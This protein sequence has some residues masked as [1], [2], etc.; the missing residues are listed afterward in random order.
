MVYVV[1][2]LCALIFF[3][4]Q[5]Y[6]Y[7]K[8]AEK[9][10]QIEIEKSWGNVPDR[11]YS[12]E[13]LENISRYYDLKKESKFQIDDITWND[14]DLDRIFALMNHSYSSVGDEFLYAWLRT[15]VKEIKELERRDQLISFFEEHSETAKK[16]SFL[17]S[18]LGRTKKGSVYENLKNLDSVGKRSNFIHYIHL[19]LFIVSLLSFFINSALGIGLLVLTTAYNVI[20]YYR[21]KAEVDTYFIC[22]RYILALVETSKQILKIEGEEL[23]EYQDELQQ[24]IKTLKKL[25]SGR[26]LVG[27][28][29]SSGDLSE[30]ILDYV[31]MLTHIDL[32][33]IN[34][35]LT[36]AIER[37]QDV[38]RIYACLGRIEACISVASFR[39]MLPYYAKFNYQSGE[40]ILAKKIYHPL[41]QN[42][43]AN[44][45]DEEQVVLLTG[46]NASGKSTFL[47]TIAI[48]AI[49]AQTIF[50]A[51]AK[52]FQSDFYQ[53]YSSMALHDNLANNE[54]YYIV[55]IKSLKRIL[56]AAKQKTKI[57]CFVDE[58][59]RGT[60]TVERIAASSRILKDM[61]DKNIKVFAATH[62]IEL[63]HILENIFSNYHFQEE[64]R[65]QD[66]QFDYLLRKGR[67]TSRNAIKLLGMMG[68]DKN[69]I[70][71][72][73][74]SANEFLETGKWD[75]MN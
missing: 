51:T 53:V 30:I 14:L 26:I 63:T 46:S 29:V 66:V 49:L 22:I 36:T 56:D 37:R 73:E 54:S 43:V 34:S 45:I 6:K 2:V 70:Q 71:S 52:E 8:D 1:M 72:A 50:T 23:K 62:D 10:K 19:G 69:L 3:M 4:F 12:Y 35:I 11:E 25:E 16:I 13:E 33:K 17:F 7:R 42:A 41:I 48:N 28:S 21:K 5:T 44:D 9:K 31:R 27:A 32:I 68:Y 24:C 38:E 18:K 57:L 58:V 59:L 64:V 15:P 20:D 40:R 67:A 39:T 65:E 47:K 61:A 74:N 75:I 55:E 60:N